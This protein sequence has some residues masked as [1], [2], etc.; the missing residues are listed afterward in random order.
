MQD[1]ANESVIIDQHLPCPNPLCSSSDAFCRYDDGHGF[2]FSC[3]HYEHGDSNKSYER[4]NKMTKQVS[5]QEV[6]YKA[7]KSRKISESICRKYK[8]GCAEGKQFAAYFD[9]NGRMVAQK[10]RTKDK[11]F[12]WVGEK[13]SATLFGQQL[14]LSGG[15]KI[16]VTEGELDCLSYAEIVKGKWPVVSVPDGASGAKKAIAT[17]LKF[18]DKF[19][20]VIFMFDMDEVGKKAA[21]ECSQLFSPNKAKIAELPLKD[22]SEMLQAG[23]EGD[24]NS[25]IWNAQPYKPASILELSTVLDDILEKP[26]WGYSF[27]WESLTKLTYGFRRKE[28]Y[29]LGAGVGIGKSDWARELARHIIQEHKNPIGM[30]MLEESYRRTGKSIV[31]KMVGTMLHRPDIEYDAK[32]IKEAVSDTLE[33]K[34]YFYDHVGTK[35]WEDVKTAM[36]YMAQVQGVK[37]FFLDPITALVSHLSSSEAND[38]INRI[39]GDIAGLVHELDITVFGF[40]HLNTPRNGAAAH[41]LGGHVNEHQFTGSRGLMRYGHYLFGLERNKHPEL[42][43][44]E[45]NSTNFVLLK[46]REFGNSGNFC[47]RYNKETGTYLEPNDAKDWKII[48]GNPKQSKDNQPQEVSGISDF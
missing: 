23:Q 35:D 27:P 39:A 8:Y 13:K 37:D 29:Y 46:D 26:T 17:N 34:I 41:E 10:Y 5:L 4:A 44:V 3:S 30:F 47:I 12:G 22:A 33:D 45:K 7:L 48:R 25:A 38:E 14:W 18:F 2:C 20:E 6:T 32:A 24:L 9:S 36:R 42:S 43:D 1:L 19:E 31:G 11:E 40:S 28:A 16:V 21:I 15:R